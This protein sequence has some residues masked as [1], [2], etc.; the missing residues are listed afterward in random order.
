MLT[1]DQVRIG[2]LAAGTLL[3]YDR[4]ESALPGYGAELRVNSALDT[5]SAEVVNELLHRWTNLDRNAR[6][7]LAH[8]VL[9]KIA[10]GE[11][12][13]QASSVDDDDVSLR[14]RLEQLLNGTKS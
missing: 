6:H 13:S 4:R 12:N 5:S 2:D 11:Q 7:R 3:V 14:R 1:R 8:T 9:A 10:R